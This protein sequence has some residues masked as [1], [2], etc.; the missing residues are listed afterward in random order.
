MLHWRAASCRARFGSA[1]R[2]AGLTRWFWFVRAGGVVSESV[3][4]LRF[5]TVKL[6]GTHLLPEE[7]PLFKAHGHVAELF[8]GRAFGRA[9]VV[10]TNQRVLV[11]D[12]ASR[13]ILG[14]TFNLVGIRQVGIRDGLVAID[15]HSPTGHRHAIT[16]SIIPHGA[17]LA[18]VRDLRAVIDKT[19]HTS[20]DRRRSKRNTSDR[21]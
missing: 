3:D 6:V 16:A 8:S 20:T 13:A 1:L 5:Q 9:W 2:Q 18:F 4:K 21:Q 15:G 7:K 10:V 12:A 14:H 11:L 19:R 17:A